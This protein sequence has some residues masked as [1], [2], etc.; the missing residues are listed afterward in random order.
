[1]PH[2]RIAQRRLL[3]LARQFP[4]ISILGPRQI[5][6]STLARM[7]F[8]TYQYLDLEH[9]RDL[10]LLRADPLFLLS[11]HERLVIDEAQRW[12]ELFPILRSY[13][14]ESSRRRIVLLGSASPG[15]VRAISES[16]TGRVAFFEL[17]GISILEQEAPH[18]WIRGAFP[19]VHW[20][21][22]RAKP[23]DWYPAYLAGCIER[24]LP[25]LGF[26]VSSV[27]VRT[28]L[29][30]LASAQGGLCNL[31]E[32][33]GSLGTSYQTV[34]HLLDLLEGVF[35]VRRLLP[36]AANVKKRLV[37]AP[38]V[39]VRDT[40]ILHSLLGIGFTRMALLRHPKAGASFETFCIEQI[41]GHAALVDR[42][43]EVYFYRTRAGAEVDLV[44]KLERRLLP[45]E[46]K[47]G[48]SPPDTRGL[49]AC[50]A[51][52]G[53]KHGYV[54]NAGEGSVAIAPRVTMCGLREFL[55]AELG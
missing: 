26:T 23:E 32:L 47:L 21:R 31:S 43:P 9:P 22:P 48:I 53:A 18:L 1:M 38:K 20:S 42:A 30:M 51:D 14:D 37:K 34:A 46:I 55:S 7:A 49:R 50:M 10:D 6:K 3:A 35:L 44:L 52:L 54:V 25:Q 45:V 19:R 12:P 36:F 40:G 24:D 11:Q 29:A 27:R 8:P 39:Y 5:G 17:G 4:A 16:L 33:G 13:L 15:L 41:A 28:L 2:P